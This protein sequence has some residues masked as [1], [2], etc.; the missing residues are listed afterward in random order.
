MIMQ[1]TGAK[2]DPESNENDTPQFADVEVKRE[3]LG[4]GTPK[5]NREARV[6]DTENFGLKKGRLAEGTPAQRREEKERVDRDARRNK[7]GKEGEQKEKERYERD[8]DKLK[9]RQKNKEAAA[10]K[11]KAHKTPQGHYLC[12]RRKTCCCPSWAAVHS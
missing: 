2:K 1:H 8:K 3:V 6:G 5:K 10:I 7:E 12:Q 9:E 11:A 4:E